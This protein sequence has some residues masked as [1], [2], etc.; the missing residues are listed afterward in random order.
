MKQTLEVVVVGGAI[1]GPAA[2]SLGF[3]IKKIALVKNITLDTLE[4]AL[5]GL[6]NTRSAY[7]ESLRTNDAAC[8]QPCLA[9]PRRRLK[10]KHPVMDDFETARGTF[11]NTQKQ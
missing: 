2:R 4:A 3:R 6:K 8:T 11:T 1:N 10:T 7:S 5:W 9:Q